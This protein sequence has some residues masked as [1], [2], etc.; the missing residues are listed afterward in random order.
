[1][2]ENIENK[3]ELKDK[4]ISYYNKNKIIFLIFFLIILIASTI[5]IFMEKNYEKKNNLISEKYIQ[6]GLLLSSGNI[7]ISKNIYEEIILS[8]NKFYSILSLNNIIENNLE[9][10]KSKILNYFN[11]LEKINKTQEQEDLIIF[12][13]AL[14]LIKSKDVSEGN[15][16]LKKLIDE[17]SKLKILAKEVITKK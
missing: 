17:N 3:I 14:F 15:K 11:I 4:L 12:K 6:A 8:E 1:M 10:D 5:F 7:E 13:K 16:L 9:K 2:S